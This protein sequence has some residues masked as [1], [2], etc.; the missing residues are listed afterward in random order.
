VPVDVAA[1]A[2]LR[3]SRRSLRNRQRVVFSGRL[4]G[5][6]LPKTGKVLDLQAYYRGRWRT[7]ATPRARGAGGWRYT[8]RFGATRGR[9]TYRFRAVVRH[10][11]DY[12]YALG[13]SNVVSVTVR[14][15]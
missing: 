4:P 2:Q 10:E 7:F 15:P 3:A 1:A 11:S 8:Y 13:Y 6:P 14:G 9:F 5:R 12:P